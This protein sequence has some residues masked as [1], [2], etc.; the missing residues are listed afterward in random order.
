MKNNNSPQL[1]EFDKDH[2]KLLISMINILL[3]IISFQI[4]LTR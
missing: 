4:H 1:H 2:F 3:K